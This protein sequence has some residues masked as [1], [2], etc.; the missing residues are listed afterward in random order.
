[1]YDGCVFRPVAM[2]APAMEMVAAIG[3]MEVPCPPVVDPVEGVLISGVVTCED[4]R[5]D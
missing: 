4:H 2:L 5:F 1:M 3:A